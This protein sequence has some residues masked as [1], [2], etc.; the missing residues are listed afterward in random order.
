MCVTNCVVTVIFVIM[1]NNDISLLV[2]RR[3]IVAAFGPSDTFNKD[4]LH[5]D[6]LFPVWYRVA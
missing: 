5:C 2:F 3:F 6:S 4:M 1:N